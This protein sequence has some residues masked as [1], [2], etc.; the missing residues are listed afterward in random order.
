MPH[1]HVPHYPSTYISVHH[2]DRNLGREGKKSFSLSECDTARG[3]CSYPIRDT[4]V[5]TS[6]RSNTSANTSFVRG[7]VH[8]LRLYACCLRL[9]LGWQAVPPAAVGR[10]SFGKGQTE[11]VGWRKGGSELSLQFFN[12]STLA[13]ELVRST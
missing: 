12:P 3:P 9:P 7:S 13:P 4:A 8:R 1:L 6:R 2:Q 11:W 10:A 5:A